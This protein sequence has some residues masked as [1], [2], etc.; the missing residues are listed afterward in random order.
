MDRMD[1]VEITEDGMLAP[2]PPPTPP[3]AM[4]ES[5]AGTDDLDTVLQQSKA[6][7]EGI[8]VIDPYGEDEL[9]KM[10]YPHTTNIAERLRQEGV[11]YRR[12]GQPSRFE[13]TSRIREQEKMLAM[14]EKGVNKDIF[15]IRRT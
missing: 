6:T 3:Y 1:G 15:M 2:P 14:R 12:D 7:R 4:S 11:Q 5:S 13:V 8:N 9:R 10:P